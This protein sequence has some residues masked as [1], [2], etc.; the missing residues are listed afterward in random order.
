MFIVHKTKGIRILL[1]LI[2]FMLINGLLQ[3][4]PLRIDL[5]SDQRY[6]LHEA[7]KEMIKR[8]E[9]PLQI[10]IY[11]AGELPTGFKQLQYSL[12]SLLEEFKAIAPQPI[13]YQFIDINKEETL[14]RKKIINQLAKE[15]I[16]PAHLF[17]EVKGQ[18]TEKMIYPGLIMHHQNKSRALLLIKSHTM[19]STDQ[20]IHQSIT[21]LEYEVINCLANLT[22]KSVQRIGI[23]E[24]HGGAN[25]LQ[26]QGFYKC[27]KSSYQTEDVQLT[28]G[29]DLTPYA[30]LFITKPQTPFSEI[31]KYYLDQYIMQG[32]KVLF[33][34]DR[35]K[36]DLEQ[37]AQGQ[38]F[39]FPLDLNLDDQLFKYGIRINHDLI[40]DLQCGIYPMIVGKMGNQPQL[41]FLPW[42]FF[43]IL[44]NF[45]DHVITKQMNALYTQFVSSMEPVQSKEVKH[46]ALAFSSPRS[47]RSHTPVYVDVQTLRKP[48]DIHMYNQG[49]LPVVYLVEGEFS[50]LYKNRLPPPGAQVKESTTKS[51]PTKLVVASTGSLALNTV[52][53]QKNKALPWGY[54]PFLQQTFGNQDFVMNLLEYML[55]EKG[56]INAKQKTVRLRPLDVTKV[57]QERLYWQLVNMLTP[58][59]L[60][61]I[62]GIT[63]QLVR[64]KQYRRR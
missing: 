18:R 36:I 39:A 26:L 64:R 15:G 2:G 46:T 35:F 3:Y 1:T 13:T 34:L 54:D 20:M 42:P 56:I 21:N 24:N 53:R 33:F 60:L 52:S 58:L 10:K 41:K 37:L 31:E 44:N 28:A 61:M 62:M 22:N 17:Q 14:E 11:L 47:S 49:P 55:S 30:A 4:V 5:T 57:G 32:G 27:L 63:W 43:P 23:V 9:T 6:T 29:S 51:K 40:K 59:L 25:P 12:Q 8:L 50:S 38:S 19:M 7:S 16:E 45:G 48:P